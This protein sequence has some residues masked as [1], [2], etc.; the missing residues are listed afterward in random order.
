MKNLGPGPYNSQ[1]HANNRK[2][3]SGVSH[4]MEGKHTCF[5]WR[6]KP[7]KF[8]D[9]LALKKVTLFIL[10]NSNMVKPENFDHLHLVYH[11]EYL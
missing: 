5:T 9:V 11:F 3:F 7:E 8:G 1:R 2:Y 10:V 6:G 4:E